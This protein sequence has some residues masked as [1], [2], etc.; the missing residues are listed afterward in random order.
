MKEKAPRSRSPEKM[1]GKTVEKAGRS[2]KSQ[3]PTGLKY[4]WKRSGDSFL[5]WC[6]CGLLLAGCFWFWSW[7][8]SLDGMV[9]FFQNGFSRDGDFAVKEVRQ[10]EF[11]GQKRVLNV[12]GVECVFRWCPRG[13]FRMGSPENE[14]GRKEEERLHRVVLSQGF[15]ILETEVTR[16][17]WAA[18]MK[19]P[20]PDE[21]EKRLPKADLTWEEAARFCELFGRKTGYRAQFPTEAQWEYACRAGSGRPFCGDLNQTGWHSGNSKAK[22]HP[23]KKKKGNLWFLYDMHGN[24]AEWCRDWYEESFYVNAPE[25]DPSGPAQGRFRVLR[26]GSF[27]AGEARCRAAARDSQRNVSKAGFRPVVEFVPPE[28]KS[29]KKQKRSTPETR[30]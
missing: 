24:A 23:A 20:L 13:T 26:G 28:K 21:K 10:G 16:E 30:H 11:A 17:L 7:C 5:V 29:R 3:A 27:E 15:W 8:G 1:V 12:N 9:H 22:L 2:P 4:F 18:V 6:F 25:K 19:E 14:K